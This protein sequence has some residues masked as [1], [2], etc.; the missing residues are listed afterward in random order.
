MTHPRLAALS[1]EHAELSV[2]FTSYYFFLS[3]NERK[4][5]DVHYDI[6]DSATMPRRKNDPP[7]TGYMPGM[8]PEKKRKGFFS[9]FSKKKDSKFSP[10]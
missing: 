2:L 6:T 4:A 1:C 3:A 7:Q 9:F 8:E 10:V 5:F